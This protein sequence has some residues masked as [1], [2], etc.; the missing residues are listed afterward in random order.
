MAETRTASLVEVQFLNRD[1]HVFRFALEEDLGFLG[2]QYIIVNTGVPLADGKVAKR[3]Y[4]LFSSDAEQRVFEVAVRR[5]GDGPGSNA[6]LGM[7]PG[8]ELRF[9]GPWGKFLATGAEENASTRPVV[10]IATDTGI[11]AA[12]GLVRSRGFAH[13]LPYTQMYWMVSSGTYFLPAGFI[14]ERI[15]EACAQFQQRHLPEDG[16][17]REAWLA[18]EGHALIEG[19]LLERPQAVYLSGDGLVLKHVR[20]AITGRGMGDTAVFVESFFHHQQLKAE[21]AQVAPVS[22]S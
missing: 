13:L 4:S 12:L 3:A 8:D 22:A 18:S 20:N 11:T 19:L 14:E 1:T 16:E 7:K 21:M 6:M 10:V 5:V 17:E 2:G 9:T 15:P